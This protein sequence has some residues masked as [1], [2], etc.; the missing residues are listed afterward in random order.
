MEKNILKV[1]GNLIAIQ[2]KYRLQH[3]G[4]FDKA[5]FLT[6]LLA[7]GQ[8]TFECVSTDT[9]RVDEFKALARD[10]RAAGLDVEEKDETIKVYG[11]HSGSWDVNVFKVTVKFPVSPALE[12]LYGQS[13]K[14]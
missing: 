7:H 1:F 8:W 10:C 9:R 3:L 11:F 4:A 5:N 2:N 14:S 13:N 6:C 12:V